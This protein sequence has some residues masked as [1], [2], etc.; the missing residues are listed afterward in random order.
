MRKFLILAALIA[1]LAVA[2]VPK[3]ATWIAPDARENGDV[4]SP[5]EIA[6]YDL[7]CTNVDTGGIVYAT[8]LPPTPTSHATPNVFDAGDFRCRMRTIDTE[9]RVSTWAQSPVFTV[10]RCETSNCNPQPPRSIVIELP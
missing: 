5:D 9:G 2:Q 4:L 10:G 8:A 1:P 7:E 6:G 3:T